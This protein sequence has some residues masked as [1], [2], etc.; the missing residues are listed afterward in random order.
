MSTITNSNP[1]NF[2]PQ[3][4]VDAFGE[5]KKDTIV[6]KKVPSAV[7]KKDKNV[8]VKQNKKTNPTAMK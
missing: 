2:K 4:P 6:N 5:K 8:G 1:K 7:I 3:D